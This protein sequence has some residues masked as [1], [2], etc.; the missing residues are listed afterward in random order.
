M[1]VVTYEDLR[2]DAC[3]GCRGIWFDAKELTHLWNATPPARPV[4]EAEGR[5]GTGHPDW[6]ALLLGVDV[7]AG[8]AM[9]GRGLGMPRR[10]DVAG[11][12]PPGST[13]AGDGRRTEDGARG[14]LID[15]AAELGMELGVEALLGILFG[16]FE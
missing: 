6:N 3:R 2:L 10:H 12:R 11:R 9:A 8:V 14:V 1:Q 5:E 4:V 13:V 7:D 15:L 16:L